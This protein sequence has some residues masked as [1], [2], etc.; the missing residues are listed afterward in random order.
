MQL[1]S[2]CGLEGCCT[3]PAMGWMPGAAR[4]LLS[5][6]GSAQ[7]LL[8]NVV[9][10]SMSSMGAWLPFFG[11]HLAPRA[12]TITGARDSL[13]GGMTNVTMPWW[14]E[15]QR[16]VD[17]SACVPQSPKLTSGLHGTSSTA[18]FVLASRPSGVHG[19]PNNL[20]W[21]NGSTPA[22]HHAGPQ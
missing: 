12:Q 7:S 4:S 6:Q 11:R 9:L 18:W 8:L 19:W 1:T 2:V 14:H 22:L 21:P 5:V 3:L 16:G 15:M 20:L 10:C 13:H 17:G